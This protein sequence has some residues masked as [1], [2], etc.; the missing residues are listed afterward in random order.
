[1]SQSPY[2]P[3]EE[4]APWPHVP[5][6][7]YGGQ[8]GGPFSDGYPEPSGYMGGYPHPSGPF[9]GAPFAPYQH[10][11]PFGVDP[12]TGLPYSDKS[13]VVAGLLGIFLGA[14]GVGR[15]YTGH[16]GLAIA[17]ILV[18]WLTFGFGAIWPL[19]DG[20]IMLAGQPR[21]RQGRPLRP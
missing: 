20:I 6:R 14:F 19:I 12:I 4:D 15:F 8:P 7:G 17:Q 10:Y 3:R 2:A 18:T 5:R 13:K 16:I 21:D 1:M 11:A 9:P